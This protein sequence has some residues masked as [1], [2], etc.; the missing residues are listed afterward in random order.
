MVDALHS[1]AQL[2]TVV[3]VDVTKVARLRAK[4]KEDFKAREGVNLTFLPFFVLAAIEGLKA[5]PKINGV[6]EGNQI[7]Y[8]APGERRHRRRHREGPARAGHP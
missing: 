5:F 3:E 7:T 1:Q 8:H 6:L 2:T 4:A